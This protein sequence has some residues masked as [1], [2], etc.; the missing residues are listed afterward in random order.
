MN[1]PAW[2]AEDRAMVRG[3]V[4]DGLYPL[5]AVCVDCREAPKACGS[6]RCSDCEREYVALVGAAWGAS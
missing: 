3:M 4:A 2:T 1:A 6:V 5:A